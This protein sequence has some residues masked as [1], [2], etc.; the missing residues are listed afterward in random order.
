MRMAVPQIQNSWKG[1]S[2]VALIF[3]LARKGPVSAGFLALLRGVAFPIPML[4]HRLRNVIDS[5]GARRFVPLILDDS[6][7]QL[8]TVMIPHES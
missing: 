5:V 2:S 1:H 4:L 6:D 8:V 3:P 7:E